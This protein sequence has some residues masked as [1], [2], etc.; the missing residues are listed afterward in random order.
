MADPA[1]TPTPTPPLAPA[2]PTR[3]QGDLEQQVLAD[4]KLGEDLAAAAAD[5]AH[6]AKLAEEGLPATAPADLAALAQD[7]RAL[8][9]QVLAAKKAKLTATQEGEAARQ[10]LLAQL[11]FLQQR[12]K[13]RFPAGDPK[14]AAYGINKANFGW[15]R[16]ELEQDAAD[17]LEGVKPEK[18]AAAKAALTVWIQADQD[19]HKAEETQAKRLGDLDAKVAALNARRRD[20]QL[21]ADTAW[22]PT[23]P[24]SAPFRRAFKLPANRPVGR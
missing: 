6:A 5:A 2:K 13:R 17:A 24:A 11:R 4:I 7:T 3:A 19:Q 1:P 15:S 20:L 9:G 8:A 21:L 23:D 10:T 14:R 18:L 22:P 12:A 16:A